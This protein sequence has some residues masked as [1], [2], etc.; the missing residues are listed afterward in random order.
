MTPILYFNFSFTLIN[1]PH[2]PLPSPTFT[3]L[4]AAHAHGGWE[5]DGF[6]ILC[7]VCNIN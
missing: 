1:F 5:E 7:P 3:I 6:I 2:D 4:N